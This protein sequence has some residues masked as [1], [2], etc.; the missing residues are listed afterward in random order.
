MFPGLEANDLRR[1][2]WSWRWKGDFDRSNDQ[3]NFDFA[4]DRNFEQ[5]A[6]RFHPSTRG[7]NNE[8]SGSIV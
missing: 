7:I 5:R 1:R 3:S 8:W 4:I 6:G 2:G